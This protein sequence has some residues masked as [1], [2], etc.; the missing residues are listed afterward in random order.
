MINEQSQNKERYYGDC[1][2]GIDVD[3]EEDGSGVD[4]LCIHRS[5]RR[6]FN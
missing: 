1:Y 3:A 5:K 4:Y 6:Q 2:A